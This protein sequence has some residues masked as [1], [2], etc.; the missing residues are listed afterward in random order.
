MNRQTAV[1]LLAG[2]LA[3]GALVAALSAGRVA[4]PAGDEA[5]H[6]ILLGPGARSEP[7]ED[8]EARIA[9]LEEAIAA[10][11]QARQWLEEEILYLG[12]ELER[13]GGGSAGASAAAQPEPVDAQAS[14]QSARTRGA[15]R[16]LS[17]LVGAGFTPAEAEW[18]VRRESELTMQAL[19]ERYE[20][21]R[22]GEPPD[23]FAGRDSA[24]D[25]LR[26]ELGD[27]AYER[28]L[29][30]NRRSTS[31]AVGS[32][33]ESSPAQ[34]AGLLAGD[35]IVSYDGRRVFD[36]SDLTELTKAGEPGQAVVVDILRGGQPMQVV[37]PRGPLGI[38]GGRRYAR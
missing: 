32:V 12:S 13:L 1:L 33:L 31:I 10:E 4:A 35:E 15:G 25:E 37:I 9:S 2:G 26:A 18:I 36:L 5:A 3:A 29:E 17:R 24:S 22:R 23:Y 30:A 20:A 14:P 8:L 27:A 38:T 28:Y 16:E 11:R 7:A 21:D 19:R 6:S 34:S